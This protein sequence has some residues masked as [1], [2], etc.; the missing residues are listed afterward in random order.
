MAPTAWPGP[1][2]RPDATLKPLSAFARRYVVVADLMTGVAFSPLEGG[3]VRITLS[4]IPVDM[5][6]PDSR[7][8]DPEPV[9]A[10]AS[11]RAER[12]AEIVSQ[13][14]FN[15]M[16]WST[17]LPLSPRRTPYTLEL[18]TTVAMF[19]ALL[20][21]R[22]KLVFNQ[23]RPHEL[24]PRVQPMIATPGFSAYPS[25][26]AT[27]SRLVSDLLLALLEGCIPQDWKDVVP[28]T[29]HALSDRVAENRV[30]A[31][32]HYP[33][34]SDGGKDM[35]KQVIAALAKRVKDASESGRQGTTSSLPDT[36]A[37]LWQLARAEWSTI[38]PPAPA[39]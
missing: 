29:L 26:H 12:S 28:K 30:V 27:E 36:F 6:A 8:F 3:G 39:A 7:A 37:E 4:G 15:P 9:V 13:M 1:A 20:V 11:L 22:V 31:G 16:L 17:V 25:G 19:G 35:A 33:V 18:M 24:S 10:A 21:Q 23:P 32:V 2:L 34:D 38:A 5:V 14:V